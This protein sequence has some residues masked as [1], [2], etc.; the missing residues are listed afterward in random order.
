MALSENIKKLRK[1]RNLLSSS[2]QTGFMCR[3]RQFAD[4][5][6]VPDVRI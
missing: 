5:K 2:L 6:M 3:D 1:R 4:G